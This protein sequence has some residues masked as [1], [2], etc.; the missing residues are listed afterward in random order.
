MY[1]F[2]HTYA[3]IKCVVCMNSKFLGKLLLAY[4]SGV[5]DS[6][7]QTQGKS[8][9]SF[10]HLPFKVLEKKNKI[11]LNKTK[12]YSTVRCVVVSNLLTFYA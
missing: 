4:L 10:A 1:L 12:L 3:H 5:Y 11:K 8:F 9:V 7:S 2:I 6:V